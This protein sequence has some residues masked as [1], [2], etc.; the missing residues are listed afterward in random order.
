M[1]HLPE[2][3]R[4]L[5]VILITASAVSLL[6]RFLKQPVILGYMAAGLIVGPALHLFPTL[7]DPGAIQTWA[8]IGVIFMLFTLGL[9]FSF[10][11][12]SQVGGTALIGG[13]FEISMMT[14]AGFVLGL[15][16][17]WRPLPSLFLGTMVAISSTS[18]I[19][20]SF[21]ET[22][23][24]AKKFAHVVYGILIVEDLVA[25]LFIVLLTTLSL[26][27]DFQ[28]FELFLTGVKLIF[29]LALWLMVGL[30][31]IPWALK[32]L[33]NYLI[34]ET[35]LV[36]SVGL[37]LTMVVAAVEVGF[38]AALGAFVMGSILGE[39]TEKERIEKLLLPVKDLFSAIFFVSIGMLMN[40]HT[41]VE[42]PLMVLFIAM[43][44]ILGKIFF[45]T[46]G[47][48]FSGQPVR[49]SIFTGLSLAQIGEFSFI[50]ASLGYSLHVTDAGLSSAI[51][52]VSV[53]T[54][55]VTPYLLRHRDGLA[56]VLEKLIPK[57][58]H[59]FIHQ[60]L[61]VST[62]I[63]ANS[64]WKSVMRSYFLKIF[65]NA[66]VIVFIF[67]ATSHLLT[68]YLMSGAST[69]EWSLVSI[70]ILTLI[71]CLPFFWG[72]VFAK[73][74]DPR[75]ATLIQTQLSQ[76]FRMSL[77]FFRL[78]LALILLGSLVAQFL[79]FRFALFISLGLFAVLFLLLSKFI[80]PV[81]IWFEN[82]FLRQIQE[83]TA[84]VDRQTTPHF[85]NLTPWEA[86]LSEYVIPAEVSFAGQDLMTLKLGEKFGIIVARIQRGS[87][88]I[89]APGRNE[90]LM[91]MDRVSVIGSD[92]QLE[93][94]EEF[95]E[96]HSK[97]GYETM[98]PAN[99]S[100]EQH[101]VT[102][103]SPFVN[104]AI[105]ESKVRELTRGLI[106]GIERGENRILSPDSNTILLRGDL[107]WLVGDRFLI[108][109]L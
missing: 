61:R 98:T 107:L 63:K 87:K 109:S 44:V 102:D 23:V 50:L 15:L 73:S 53:V 58:F 70:L 18:I 71:L 21:D 27:R 29:Y 10:K 54:T 79:S 31:V 108:R 9:E 2:L 62:M 43:V 34:D 69:H 3:I 92:E 33:K 104:K 25:V 7:A 76:R 103:N 46:T 28:G 97:V 75:L 65:L 101:L 8:D 42:K 106:V 20:K 6:F 12:L 49:T 81:Y 51:V 94:F 93:K 55:F 17:G 89:L 72:I 60:Y 16:F 59:T 80:G 4:D 5:A 37:C 88:I 11:K 100:L 74:N 83:N 57:R 95:L 86:H 30:W 67:I 32:A 52:A 64:E 56:T 41:L 77:L 99:Y 68:P 1:S 35:M 78:M 105:K 96:V 39:T 85:E 48:L 45:A 13:V 47:A 36:V 14:L 38:S 22:R 90:T 66:V 24:K 82:R 91:P 19:L 84:D 40:P 26:S